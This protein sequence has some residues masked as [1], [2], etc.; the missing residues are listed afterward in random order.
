MV[1]NGTCAF[2]FVNFE[3]K[4]QKYFSYYKTYDIFSAAS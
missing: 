2:H 3:V 4:L 1:R